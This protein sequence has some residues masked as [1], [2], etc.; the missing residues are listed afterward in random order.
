MIISVLWGQM[1]MQSKWAEGVEACSSES[2]SVLQALPTTGPR[3]SDLMIYGHS[4]THSRSHTSHPN[5][6]NTSYCAPVGAPSIRPM[7][8]F[9]A[10]SAEKHVRQAIEYGECAVW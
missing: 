7:L 6:A 4:I 2:F 5:H 3:N 9:D 1:L 10:M 8:A